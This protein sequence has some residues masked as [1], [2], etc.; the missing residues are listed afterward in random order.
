MR[1]KGKELL[2]WKSGD[3]GWGGW[4][5]GEVGVKG[6]PQLFCLREG[7][8]LPAEGWRRVELTREWV[9][10]LELSWKLLNCDS[11]I[12]TKPWGALAA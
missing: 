4:V 6:H 7:A 8:E 12:V 10:R 9:S 1:R 3:D 5:V 2:R 11:L